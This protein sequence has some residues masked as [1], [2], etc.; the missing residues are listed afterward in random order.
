MPLVRAAGGMVTTV[1]G[2]DSRDED[3]EK[4][5]SNG[6]IHEELLEAVSAA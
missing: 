3:L 1:A 2:T 6:L 5:V 4:V